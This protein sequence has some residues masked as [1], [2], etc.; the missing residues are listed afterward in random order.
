[1]NRKG[2]SA[3]E[4]EG[5]AEE[6]LKEELQDMLEAMEGLEAERGRDEQ[7][8]SCGVRLPFARDRIC[9]QCECYASGHIG[10]LCESPICFE[11][12]RNP[13]TECLTAWDLNFCTGDEAICLSQ[14]SSQ[15]SVPSSCA[16]KMFPAN[17]LPDGVRVSY[18]A[19]V[20]LSA[21]AWAF[22]LGG[23]PHFCHRRC[24]LLTLPSGDIPDDVRRSELFVMASHCK[25]G[26]A[27]AVIMLPRHFVGTISTAIAGCGQERWA[28]SC[29]E[30]AV[31]VFKI[32]SQGW[33]ALIVLAAGAWQH[34]F[35]AGQALD[36]PPCRE[37][38]L[39]LFDPASTTHDGAVVV[40]HIGIVACKLLGIVGG[41][42]DQHSGFGA[43]GAAAL[44]VSREI[45][46]V[47]VMVSES[48]RTVFVASAGKL[49][50][51]ETAEAL[52]K[53]LIAKMTVL[54]M[55]ENLDTPS[56]SSPT[57]RSETAISH[58]REA[59]LMQFVQGQ[60]DPSIGYS[61]AVKNVL[62]VNKL[63]RKSCNGCNPTGSIFDF[64]SNDNGPGMGVQDQQT[65]KEALFKDCDLDTIL[66]S[67]QASEALKCSVFEVL[68]SLHPQCE[69]RLGWLRDQAILHDV[70]PVSALRLVDLS[71][72]AV[73]RFRSVYYGPLEQAFVNSRF[74]PLGGSEAPERRGGCR[75]IFVRSRAGEANMRMDFCADGVAK[76]R[77]HPRYVMDWTESWWLVEKS[78]L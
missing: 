29:F 63:L 57:M 74:P 30:V 72:E 51:M 22:N 70:L 55:S 77:G 27:H 19:K 32:C 6:R 14:S 25:H 13:S 17:A 61:K 1:M 4:E 26:K 35:S 53:L 39:R 50:K 7:C 33:G 75:C 71:E 8:C 20:D 73:A 10:H 60:R 42:T 46:C 18:D 40:S 36:L 12:V 38:L 3:S 64:L 54:S 65:F 34:A 21:N 11:P 43:R 23:D 44:N 31:A 67:G 9:V 47:A 41:D 24:I 56:P 2:S 78:Q 66:N 16:A 5:L 49:V 76:L 59:D 58:D 52:F 15:F 37:C 62:V 28:M 69:D 45:A 48:R 68:K